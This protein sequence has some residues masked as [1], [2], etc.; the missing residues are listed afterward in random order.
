[1]NKFVQ[2]SRRR[3]TRGVYCNETVTGDFRCG[4]AL[5]TTIKNCKFMGC[6]M[7]GINFSGSRFLNCTFD[8]CTMNGAILNA[9]TFTNCDFLSC[10]LD[11]ARFDAAILM[12]C[13]ILHGRAEYSSFLEASITDSC[14]DTQLHGAD[15]RYADAT[16]LDLGESNLWGA[17]ITASCAWFS[18][19]RLS[20]RQA[21]LFLGLVGKACPE[22]REEIESVIAPKSAELLLA[23]MGDANGTQ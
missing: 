19:N 18:G 21:E 1:M 5:E 22:K 10:E 3:L 2:R 9:S 23:L 17:S 11:L 13:K 20:P 15:L 6:R 12:N 8:S 7:D 14:F 16:G 4:L